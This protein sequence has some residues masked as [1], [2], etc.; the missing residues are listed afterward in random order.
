[1]TVLL[2]TNDTAVA[3]AADREVRL[4]DGRLLEA[5]PAAAAGYS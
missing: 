2:V 1:M 5:E 3:A 4:R